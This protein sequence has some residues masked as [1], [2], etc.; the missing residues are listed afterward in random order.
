MSFLISKFVQ[1]NKKS[2]PR[3]RTKYVST[4]V[5][6][7][8][9]FT[10]L[11]KASFTLEAACVIPLV[12]IFLTGILFYFRAMQVET[13]VYSA[14]SYASRKTAAICSELDNDVAARVTAEAFFRTALSEYDEVADYVTGGSLGVSLLESDF[15]GEYVDLKA[16][17][18][19]KTPFSFFSFGYL[20]VCQE[21]KSRKWIGKQREE[22]QDPWVFVTDYGRVYHS[23]TTCNYL[24]LSVHGAKTAS[25]A[26]LRNYNAHK[27]Y[28]CELCVAENKTPLCVYI[29]N[30]GEAYHTSLS[31]S[32]LKR[33]IHQV[34]K[35]KVGNK[36]PCSK[37]VKA[38]G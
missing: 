31:C 29:T 6:R 26:Y 30:Y 23:T 18:L 10:R 27:Y 16:R 20:Y 35:S 24:D 15:S 17:Y 1:F 36:S 2:L 12:T 7:T 22:E 5:N 3:Y 38:K 33:T 21:S 14:L 8:P 9:L 32:G 19:L 11:N 4:R 13:E 37:C 25:L 34:R 28:A